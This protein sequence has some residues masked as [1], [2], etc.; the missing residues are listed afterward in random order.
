MNRNI[1]KILSF[2]TIAALLFLTACKTYEYFDIEILEPAELFFPQDM[3]NLVVAHNI[4]PAEGDTIGKPFMIYGQPGQD[5]V[6]IDTSLASA[7]INGL[8]E[9][10]NFTRRFAAV[11][12]DSLKR[13]FTKSVKEYTQNDVDYIRKLCESR[14]SDALI[15]LNEIEHNNSYDVFVSDAGGYFGEF[16]VTI[17]TEWL[18]INPFKSKLIDKKIIL[19]TI[20]YQVEPLNIDEKNNGFEARKEALAQVA[21]ISGNTYGT[22]ISPHYMQTS[23]IVFKKGDKNIKTGFEQ[24]QLGNWKNAAFFWREA[25]ISPERKIQALA[26]FN[27]AL[28][29]EM[30]GLLEPALEWAKDSYRYF[31]DT[32]NATYISILRERIKQQKDLILQMGDEDA[33]K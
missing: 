18:F 26:S 4:F 15:L 32:L 9:M 6:Y 5:S 3:Q 10:L 21:L 25:L 19:D 20:Y 17:K 22:H 16:E 33:G 14:S 12:E 2:F 11:V 7:A 29:N 1:P 27:L 13:V 24:A 28:A 30:E 23:R 31:P 8:T